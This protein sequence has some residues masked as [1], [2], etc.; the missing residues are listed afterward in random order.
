MRLEMV[1]PVAAQELLLALDELGPVLAQRQ[2]EQVLVLWPA[3]EADVP[4]EWDEETF[5]ELMFFLR[6]WKGHDPGRSLTVLEERPLE[7][8][9][10]V[11]RLAS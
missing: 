1:D 8:P 10:E 6:A 4:D 3:G 7:L 2:D 5:A 9:D 11:F